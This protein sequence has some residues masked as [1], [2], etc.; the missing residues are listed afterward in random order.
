M[1]GNWGGGRGEGSMC[2]G[3]ACK[4]P[5]VNCGELQVLKNITH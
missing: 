4:D 1:E 5:E 3:S 2:R